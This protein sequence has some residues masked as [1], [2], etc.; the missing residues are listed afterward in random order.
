MIKRKEISDVCVKES[1]F[2]WKV[3]IAGALVTLILAMPTCVGATNKQQDVVDVAFVGDTIIVYPP[4]A[5]AGKDI[6]TYVGF[7]TQFRGYGTSPD[8][9]IIKCEWDF[10]G[11]DHFD[12][13]STLSGEAFHMYNTTGT[14]YARI[15]VYDTNNRTDLDSVKVVVKSEKSPHEYIE[16]ML[17]SR[18]VQI[19]LEADGIKSRYVVMIN[20]GPERRYWDDVT[21]MYSTLIND[22]GF[23]ADNIYLFNHD[24]KNPDGENPNN[25]IDFPARK[26]NIGSVFSELTGIIDSDDLLF[27]WITNH[28]K[29]YSGPQSVYYGYLDGF[30]S[31]DPGDEEDYLESDFK[32][33]SFYTGGNYR[34]NH[35]M[36]V[37]KVRYKYSSSH[38]AY[39]VYRNKYVSSFTDIYF[40]GLNGIIS[41]DD[42]FI[43]KFVDYPLGDTDRD[44]YIE[45]SEGEV[46]DYDGDGNPPYDHTTETFDEDDWGEIDEYEDNIKHLNTNV[47]YDNY[48]YIIFD[49]GFDNCVDIDLYSACDR[50]HLE[51]C[52]VS[53]LE[54]DGTDLDNQGLFDGID[55]NDDGDMNDWVS[56]DEMI[57]LYDDDLLDDEMATYLSA[58]NAGKIV[59][60]I[61]PCFS[62]GFI[63]DLSDPNRVILTATVEEL[64]SWGNKFLERF[65]TALHWADI[66]GNPVNADSDGNGYISMLEAFNY[67]AENDGTP[68]QYD[69]NGDGIG[70]PY[71]IPN[72]G[73]GNLGAV[74]YLEIIPTTLI[75]LNSGWNLISLPLMPEDT[76]ITSLLSSI[77]G[78][79]SIV[80]EYN[81]SDTS[82]HWKKYDPNA[83]IGNDLTDMEPGKGYLIMMISNDTLSIS[84]TVPESTDIYLNTDWNL[85]GYNSLNSQPVALECTP[86]PADK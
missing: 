74:I 15:R 14:Y 85:I 44:G 32:L 52:D 22:Y 46:Y 83:P 67:A 54:V 17:P 47:P 70:H 57:C 60:V 10:D 86:L 75:Q 28:G 80:W 35:G 78:N 77:N 16:P 39:Q 2:L 63:E 72:G 82:D 50:Y 9:E 73:D 11:D 18:Q 68:P 34:C 66:N 81:A 53:L 36:D 49:D 20:G 61:L 27:I 59:V 37:W 84:G 29:G 1:R 79:Y 4:T 30:A 25:M 65:T 3:L 56:I 21:F 38:S 5:H 62:G 6:I 40:E 8:Y 43:E 76:S 42:I 7:P 55:I 33:R 69:D 24:G 48:D 45:K 58:I 64:S 19:Y 23:T 13:Y 31:V 26:S 12:W 71:P 41:D 51:D